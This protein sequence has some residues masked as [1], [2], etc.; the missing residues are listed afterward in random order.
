MSVAV[1]VGRLRP[2]AQRV[3]DALARQDVAADLEVLVMDIE[4]ALEPISVPAPLT[5][6]HVPLR[7]ALM[8]QGKGEAVRRASAPVIAFL[9]DHCYPCPGWARALIEAHRG[10]WAAVGYAFE[11]ANPETWVSR[12]GMTSDYG[13]FVEP[14]RGPADFISGNNVSYKR[15]VLLRFG[16]R[17]DSL[18]IVDHNLQSALREQGERLFIEP[19]ALAAHE[20]Y[21]TVTEVGRANASF[22]RAMA[23]SRADGWSW[24]R[25]VFYALAAP[26]AAPAIKLI[27]L[28][29]SVARR[30][31]AIV[32]TLAALPV[33]LAAYAWGAA[34]ESRGYLD[35][36]ADAAE[37][38]FLVWELATARATPE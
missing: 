4:P 28:A 24:P 23:A 3:V 2:R 30:P 6:V 21:V 37:L 31:R 25:R 20:N 19:D 34:G 18:L 22:C 16:D 5:G 29:R 32:R 17:L 36:S 12:A 15:D 13:M 11:N 1:I 35:R 14:R 8:S 10:P 7:S 27:R 33:I 9:E 26:V 38:E